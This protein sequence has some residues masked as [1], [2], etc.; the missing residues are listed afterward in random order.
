MSAAQA[1]R[2]ARLA[3]EAALAGLV[4]PAGFVRVNQG[5]GCQAT[6]ASLCLSSALSNAAAARAIEALLGYCAVVRDGAARVAGGFALAPIHGAD[7][8]DAGRRGHRPAPN[9]GP[10]GDGPRDIPGIDRRHRASFHLTCRRS[11]WR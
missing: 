1:A 9:C 7:R 3:A 4:T 2:S 10:Y 6:R 8:V 11:C 5:D